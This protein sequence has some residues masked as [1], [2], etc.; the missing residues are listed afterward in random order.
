MIIRGASALAPQDWN[1]AALREAADGGRPL[2][3]ISH[4]SAL[5]HTGLSTRRLS[6]A[7]YS[8]PPTNSGPRG[9][10]IMLGRDFEN[11]SGLK[12]PKA[13]IR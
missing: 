7:T 2:A 3:D 5:H 12:T 13:K 11:P 6:T 9:A 1:Y 4:P 10:S 8:L